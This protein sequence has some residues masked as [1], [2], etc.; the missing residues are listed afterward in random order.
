M[1][2]VNKAVLIV[3]DLQ[4]TA[5]LTLCL[6]P[7]ATPRDGSLTVAGGGLAGDCRL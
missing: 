7:P 4:K 1:M 3:T 5:Y 2:T 6:Q